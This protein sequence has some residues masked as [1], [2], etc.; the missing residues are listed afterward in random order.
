ML[1][2]DLGH[3]CEDGRHLCELH[4]LPSQDGEHRSAWPRV[5][6]LFVWLPYESRQLP[7][8]FAEHPDVFVGTPCE[9]GRRSPQL[10][11][12][13]LRTCKAPVPARRDAVEVRRAPVPTCWA[14]LRTREG[15]L[16]TRP[17]TLLVRRDAL[18]I[19]R[20]APRIRWD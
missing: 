2:L 14:S 13:A 15:A 7:S 5:L 9:C 8:V 17:A 11:T 6:S 3:R 20:D 4:E 1:S 10:S 18:P 16:L 12:D 19:P